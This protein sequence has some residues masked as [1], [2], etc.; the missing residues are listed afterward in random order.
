MAF[1]EYNDYDA[2]GLAQL[3][4]RGEVSPSEL[5][6]EAIARVERHNPKLNAVIYKAYDEARRTAKGKLPDGP[7]KGVPFLIKDIG[8]AV[9]GWPM[10]SGSAY[11]K[12]YV[13]PSDSELT[14]RYRAAGVVLMGKTNTPEFGIPGTTE[15]RHLGICRNPWNPEHSSG[16]SSGGAASAVASG[17]VPMAHGSDGL[18]SIRIPA[19][20]CG[21]VG[22]KPTQSRN[23]GGPD[24]RGRA[25]GLIVDHVLTRTLRDSAAMLDWTGYPEDDAPYAAVPKTRPY[26]DEIR[27]ASGK[28]KIAYCTD[29]PS[30][31]P[32]SA[33]VQA[34]FDSTLKLLEDLGHTLIEKKE[35]PIDWRK[36][37]KAQT[38]VSGAMLVASIEEWSRALGRE[39]TEDDFEPLAWMAYT[40]SKMLSGAQVGWGLQMMRYISRQIV[41]LWRDFDVLFSPVTISPPPPIGH[42][43]PVNVNAREFNKRQ[44]RIFGYTPP[45]NMT[46]QPSI[47]LPLG[48]SAGKLPIGMMFTGRYADEATLYRLAAQLEEARPWIDHMPPIFG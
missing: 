13:S 29:T 21:L 44:S 16:G 10:T 48:M 30:K 47:S 23:P 26:M 17:M 3:V 6:E 9:E 25:H 8:C 33:D 40:G 7:F 32:P 14:R 46:G 4:R 24:D 27:T 35:L 42:L 18:G 37:Y 34:V 15:G 2:L 19:A 12:N 5:L 31:T 41:G 43:D 20:Q 22:M 11:L 45:F 1:A 28:L 39:P 38:F 36:L